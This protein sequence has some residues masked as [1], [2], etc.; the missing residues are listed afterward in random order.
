M[1]IEERFN[2][3]LENSN[4]ENTM[5]DNE[6][7]NHIDNFYLTIESYLENYKD[8]INIY[9]EDGIICI[10]ISNRWLF[11][12]LP[13]EKTYFKL[14]VEYKSEC[15]YLY[16]KGIFERYKKIKSD[17]IIVGSVE[18][19][20]KYGT[21][22]IVLVKNNKGEYIWKELDRWGIFNEVTPELFYEMLME[23]CF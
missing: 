21:Q 23:V 4:I 9:Y 3:L 19:D 6:Y 17:E 15:N 11:K 14:G 13:R 18:V 12:V 20:C 1:S 10:N 5:G 8:T 22:E 2:K 7:K 16:S